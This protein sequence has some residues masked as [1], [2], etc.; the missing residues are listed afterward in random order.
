MMEY[1]NNGE[2]LTQS[3]QHSNI[4]T[5]LCLNSALPKVRHLLIGR[6]FVSPW[7]FTVVS[8]ILQ[9]GCEQEAVQLPNSDS[10]PATDSSESSARSSVD[11]QVLPPLK[12]QPGTL[13]QEKDFQ[14]TLLATGAKLV[15]VQVYLESC[16][17]CMTEALKLSK[18]ETAWRDRGVAILGLGMDETAQGPQAFYEMTGQRVTFPLYLAP[19]FARQQEI[20]LTPTLFIYSV[21]GKQLFRTDGQQAEEGMLTALDHRLAELLMDFSE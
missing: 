4:P 18:Q 10:A 21:D 20:R 9:P 6:L 2:S 19:W 11:Q 14:Q 13:L 3:L 12:V 1:W 16:G 17:A 7:I 5:F 8:L 15:I